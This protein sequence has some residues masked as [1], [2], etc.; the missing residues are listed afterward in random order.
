MNTQGKIKCEKKIR[1]K[2]RKRRAYTLQSA[3]ANQRESWDLRKENSVMVPENNG[4]GR[5]GSGVVGA[6]ARR[7]GMVR[8]GMIGSMK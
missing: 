8:A 7:S 6:W 4:S 5:I 2:G 3:I 1:R